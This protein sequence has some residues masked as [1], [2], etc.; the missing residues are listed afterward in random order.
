MP[1][2]EYGGTVP[3]GGHTFDV[4][5]T[6]TRP[7]NTTA[8]AAN[9]A[10]LANAG[11]PMEFLNVARTAGA[12]VTIHGA[13]L[14]TNNV[15]LTATTY[16][17]WLFR[18]TPT[19]AHIAADNAAF[20]LDFDDRDSLIGYFDFLTGGTGGD[21]VWRMGTWMTEQPQ[22][23]KPTATSLFG[24]LQTLDAFTPLSAQS[25]R[26]YLFGYQD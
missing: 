17:L 20:T 7:S 8:Y 16:R 19:P 10:I 1:V 13:L 14:F 2:A 24:L 25:W 9:D 11:G 22:P 26:I 18:G 15:L 6:L 21:F 5:A 12:G 3:V 23:V 4:G